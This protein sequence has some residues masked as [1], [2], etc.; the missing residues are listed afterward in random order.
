LIAA[1][2]KL[3]TVSKPKRRNAKK[4]RPLVVKSS[5]PV[6][7]AILALDSTVNL[8]LG[9]RPRKERH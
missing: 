9:P 5:Q 6:A 1:G 8:K 3:G 4:R 7:G 2:C